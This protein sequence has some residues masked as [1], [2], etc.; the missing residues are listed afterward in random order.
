MDIVSWNINGIRAVVKKNFFES[1]E[2]LKPDILCL[3]ETKTPDYEVDIAL[4]PL[5]NFQIHYDSVDKKGYSGTAFSIKTAP[6][7]IA[8]GMDIAEHDTEGRI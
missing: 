1:I 4:A 2:K 5:T 8:Y 6:I 3:Q 7:K